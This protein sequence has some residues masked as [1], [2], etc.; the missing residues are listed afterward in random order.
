[1]FMLLSDAMA[2][3]H[4]HGISGAGQAVAEVSFFLGGGKIAESGAVQLELQGVWLRT[5]HLQAR[6]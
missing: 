6:M 1:M 5:R 2:W 4:L 3:H